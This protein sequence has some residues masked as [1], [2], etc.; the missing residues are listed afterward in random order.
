MSDTQE[1]LKK[2]ISLLDV[3]PSTLMSELPKV[4]SPSS[5][6]PSRTLGASNKITPLHKAIQAESFPDKGRLGP[7][8]TIPN[9]VHMLRSYGINT[10]Y[11]VITKEQETLIPGLKGCADNAGNTALTTITS[12][13]ILNG[14]GT[15]HLPAFV[16]AIADKNQVNPVADWIH[17]AQWDGR[18]R[19][20]GLYDTL[21]VKDGFPKSFRNSLI[22]RWLISAVAAA[23]KPSGFHCRGVLTLQGKQSIG[24][25][26]WLRALVGLEILRD[27][28]VL[29]DHLLDVGNKDSILQ[30]ESHWLVELGELESSFKRDQARLKGFLTSPG[31]K[32]RRPYDKAPSVLQRRTVF[33]AT[34]NEAEFLVDPTGNSRFWTIPVTAINYEHGIDTQQLWAQVAELF[35]SGEQWWLTK[36]EELE[37]ET[38]NKEHRV[39]SSIREQLNEYLDLDAPQEQWERLSAS[40]MLEKIGYE[41]P[42]NAQARD[43]GQELRALF[44]E[45][46]KSQGTMRWLVPPERVPAN[47][48]YLAQLV[49]GVAATQPVGGGGGA[50]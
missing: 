6:I 14:V 30:A 17:S 48:R 41:K 10:K 16:A 5:E 39:V 20:E 2:T 33:I 35:E 4:K 21:V 36:D 3:E 9:V 23:L 42:T 44:G 11:C 47:N 28:V 31:S 49:N 19:L 43:A 40:A 50:A 45:P 32:I 1:A 12:L 18:D 26:S 46:K 27:K 13:A 8:Q 7:L 37:L 25:T 34:V 29:I 38:I 22:R 24:K 15:T